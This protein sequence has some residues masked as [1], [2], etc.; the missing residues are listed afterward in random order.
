MGSGVI[1]DS[2][3]KF[4]ELASD[5]RDKITR[6]DLIIDGLYI[7]AEKAAVNDHITQY[8]IDN[9]QSKINTSYRG[10]QAIAESIQGFETLRQLYKNRL[11]GRQVRLVPDHAMKH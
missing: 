9:G 8:A 4:L 6:I 10:V 7:T 3:L 5:L 1:Y 11:N 2:E